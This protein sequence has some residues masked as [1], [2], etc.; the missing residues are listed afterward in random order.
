MNTIKLLNNLEER[1]VFRIEDVQKIT[2]RG[3]KY[4]TMIIHRLKA[5]NLIKMVT[6]N[7][8][9]TKDEICLIA[10]NLIYP[11][12]ISFWSAS[13]F[14]GYTEQMPSIIQVA[15]TRKTKSINFEG[16]KIKF[17]KLSSKEFF[18][19]RKIQSDFG[20]IFIAENEKLIIDA[21][22]KQRECGNFAE[23]EAI[24]QNAEVDTKKLIN[25]LNLINRNALTKRVGYLL[26]KTKGVD[27][28][29]KFELN[30]NYTTLDQ[31]S[32]RWSKINS[33]WRIKI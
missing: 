28:S 3:R 18:G 6:K 8:Y 25:Y 23:I 32:K 13:A 30:K 17:I 2:G 11:S 7:R 20:P 14:L 9:T 5:R 19:Y 22:N 4:S 1:P 15:V 29:D 12:Y 33:K 21:V 27:I 24:I 26:E 16:Y 31:F 10:S